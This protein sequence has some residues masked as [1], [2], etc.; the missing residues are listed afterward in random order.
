MDFAA[1]P[2]VTKDLLHQLQSLKLKTRKTRN[3]DQFCDFII[4]LL[5]VIRLM[6]FR[7]TIVH[8]FRFSIRNPF[9]IFT[10]S[11]S[12]ENGKINACLTSTN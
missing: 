3:Q 12:M 4:T 5:Q 2:P 11:N 6:Y 7:I 8:S 1:A 10:I 9:Q